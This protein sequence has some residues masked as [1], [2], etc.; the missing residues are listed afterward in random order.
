MAT[1][2]PWIEMG[3]A[4]RQ[5]VTNVAPNW[6]KTKPAIVDPHAGMIQGDDGVWRTPED[7]HNYVYKLGKY[8]EKSPEP[9]FSTNFSTNFQMPSS[10]T[11]QPYNVNLP[12]I[13]W[14]WNPTGEQKVDWRTQA[15]AIAAQEINPQLTALRNALAAYVTGLNNQRAE[16]NPRY[17]DQSL[18]IANIAKNAKQDAV[19]A[20]IRRGAETSGWL[21]ERMGAIGAGEL[22]QRAGIERQR[23]AELA[24]LAA[25]ES[26]QREAAGAQETTL[27]G[28]R[29]KRITTALAD[30]ENTAWGRN[31]SELQNQWN[32]ALGGEQLRAS[33]YGQNAA[34]ELSAW[35]TMVGAE[36]ARAELALNEAIANANQ[37]NTL[38]QQNYT[39]AQDAYQR[40]LAAAQ[41][42]AS[43]VAK[44]PMGYVQGIPYYS[45]D[46]LNT[47]YRT[48]GLGGYQQSPQGNWVYEYDM[49]TNRT[50]KYNTTT[51]ER[52]WVD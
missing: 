5:N 11:F 3:G 21:P 23:N 18:A 6:V 14:T 35:Q 34:N 15:E 37:A 47:L 16:L 46:E 10:P 28:L 1:T 44:K 17:T 8:A 45:L 7:N 22:E 36:Q 31:L 4:Q 51:G 9:D 41:K 40:Q 32:S 33:A 29:G 50:Y 26:Q 52:V 24:A 13:D 48:F 19:E 25:L 2:S 27:E 12:T 43:N 42:A 30:L 38:W 39:T 20:A 49:A